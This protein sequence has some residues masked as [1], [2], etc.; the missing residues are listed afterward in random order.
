M[1]AWL[2]QAWQA[3]WFDWSYEESIKAKLLF[4]EYLGH[5]FGSRDN[6]EAQRLAE[7]V[8]SFG[9]EERA[10]LF[11]G[12]VAVPAAQ[13]ALG[14]AMLTPQVS[15]VFPTVLAAIEQQNLGG[16]DLIAALI[17]GLEAEYRMGDHPY[18]EV[19]GALVGVSNAFGLDEEGWQVLLGLT[20]RNFNEPP[21]SALGRGLLAHDIVL[22]G[23][24]ARDE[25]STA[26]AERID[27]PAEWM[28]RLSRTADKPGL[29]DFLM[30][31]EVNADQI[32]AVYR[33]RVAGKIPAP[34]VEYYIDAVMA[35]EDIVIVPH[36]FRR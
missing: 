16:K 12:S 23:I 1:Q 5:S 3:T 8:E 17:A 14:N 19:M 31:I 4:I 20:K 35:F 32:V 10:M 7:H 21:I 11:A 25:W 30:A 33:E 34:H 36:F 6:V 18:A 29:K 22:N 15:L 13:A 9:G 24:L 26:T 27:L 2:E 28:D